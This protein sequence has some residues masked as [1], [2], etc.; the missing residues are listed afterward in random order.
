MA[1]NDAE[2]LAKAKDLLKTATS[3]QTRLKA[4]AK[5][6]EKLKKADDLER[7]DYLANLDTAFAKLEKD[8]LDQENYGAWLEDIRVRLRSLRQSA[9]HRLM[10]GLKSEF[11]EESFKILSD[12]PLSLYLHPFT[13]EVNFEEAKSAFS[14]AREVLASTSLDVQDIARLHAQQIE[15]FRKIRID[16]KSFFTKLRTAYQMQCLKES[17]PPRAHV[18]LV[19]LLTP[20]AWLWDKPGTTKKSLIPL[21]KYLLAYQLQKLRK[22]KLLSY[23]GSQLDLG[24]ATGGS[25]RKKSNVL[26][27]PQGPSEGQY[28]L[29]ITF[30]N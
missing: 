19:D 14:Y 15:E 4:L 3:K 16:S 24:V 10:Q 13:L 28:Y 1:L 20:L 18:N 12:R 26:Y 2:S 9:Q 11:S 27:I 22:D 6:L 29:S 8:D 17:L 23:N 7:Q 21:P 5:A 25:T 30:T